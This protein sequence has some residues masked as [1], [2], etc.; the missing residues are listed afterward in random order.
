[1]SALDYGTSVSSRET[2]DLSIG[3]AASVAGTASPVGVPLM[4]PHG[5]FYY[6]SA[7]WQ[8]DLARSREQLAAGDY[9]E[10]DNGLDLARWLFD[11]D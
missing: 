2:I 10:F 5:Q 6:W 9:R 3:S 4:I 1:M 11:E 8:A 7:R